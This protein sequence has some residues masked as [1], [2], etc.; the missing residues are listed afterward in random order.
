MAFRPNNFSELGRKRSLGAACPGVCQSMPVIENL[1]RLQPNP[2]AAKSRIQFRVWAQHHANTIVFFRVLIPHLHS[3]SK[4]SYTDLNNQTR[5]G[6]TEAEAY[7]EEILNQICIH[8]FA[9]VPACSSENLS[10]RLTPLCGGIVEQRSNEST[11]FQKI[12]SLQTAG[13]SPDST[14]RVI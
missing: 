8:E 3:Q 4:K 5:T 7:M 14:R 6:T 9:E 11:S 1:S 13:P 2:R 10:A 12:S